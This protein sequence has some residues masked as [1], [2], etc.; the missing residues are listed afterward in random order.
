M[1]LLSGEESPEEQNDDRAGVVRY[2]GEEERRGGGEGGGGEAGKFP[3][4]AG[5]KHPRRLILDPVV[6]F[7]GRHH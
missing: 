3:G 5:S 7:P 4:A 6:V 2:D 1:D